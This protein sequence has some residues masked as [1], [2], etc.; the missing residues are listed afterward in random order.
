MN[1]KT[2]KL[3]WDLNNLYDTIWSL[4]TKT[5]PD[6]LEFDDYSKKMK[7]IRK[8]SKNIEEQSRGFLKSDVNYIEWGEY[9]LQRTGLPYESLHK[10]VSK[11]LL[12][13]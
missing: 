1:K 2:L 3:I 4:W 8:I 9:L 11:I 7:L 12:H 6:S 10:E 13:I 5:Q